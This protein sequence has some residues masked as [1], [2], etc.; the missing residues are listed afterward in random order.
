MSSRRASSSRLATSADAF[1]RAI[2]FIGLFL[3]SGLRFVVTLLANSYGL[4]IPPVSASVNPL[5]SPPRKRE[6]ADQGYND[7][8]GRS[9]IILVRNGETLRMTAH[10]QTS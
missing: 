10:G 9:L 1:G 8:R 3:A 4:T 6:G 7:G 2:V 5:P